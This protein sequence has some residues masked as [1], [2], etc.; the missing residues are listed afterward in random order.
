M[1]ENAAEVGVVKD[2]GL[3]EKSTGSVCSTFL[4]LL[5]L[6]LV[7][8]LVDDCSVWLTT[9]PRKLLVLENREM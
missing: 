9:D 4:D 1:A 5:L 6:G 8:S 2:R 3:L 7:L